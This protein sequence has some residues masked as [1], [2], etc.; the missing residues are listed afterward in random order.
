MLIS[1]CHQVKW[2][3]IDDIQY[4]NVSHFENAFRIIKNQLTPYNIEI[5]METLEILINQ[6]INSESIDFQVN[7]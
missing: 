6:H 2:L 3:D 4:E 5:K 1:F 7:R